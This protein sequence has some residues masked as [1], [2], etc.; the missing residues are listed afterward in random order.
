[1][2]LVLLGSKSNEMINVNVYKRLRMLK[3]V[4]ECRISNHN[5]KIL[6]ER[7]RLNQNVSSE[8]SRKP[9]SD[10]NEFHK[11]MEFRFFLLYLA[12]FVLYDILPNDYI[13]HFSVLHC[14]IRILC[15][16]LNCVRNK[17]YA[18]KLLLWFVECM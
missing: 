16:I 9:R 6:N 2:H 1:M 5:Y 3:N 13:L 15:D 18:A 12:P 7:L 8:I 11:A 4:K 14:A 10:F 17:E